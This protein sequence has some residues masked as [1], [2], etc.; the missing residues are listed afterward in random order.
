MT[1]ME[2]ALFWKRLISFTAMFFL[3]TAFPGCTEKPTD[4]PP[5]KVLSANKEEKETTPTVP[6]EKTDAPLAP[7]EKTADGKEKIPDNPASST[8]TE[9]KENPQTKT[10]KDNSISE[11]LVPSNPSPTVKNPSGS[12]DKPKTAAEAKDNENEKSEVKAS[13]QDEKPL[14]DEEIRAESAARRKAALKEIIEKLGPPLVE[15]AEKLIKTDPLFPVWI[16]KESKQVVVEGLVCQTNAPLEMFA[17]L[18][19]TKEHEA[20]LA[21]PTEARVV[22]AAL[23]AVGAKPGK[24]VEFGP[25]PSDYKPATGT[26]IEITVRWKNDKGEIQ[27]GRAQEWIKNVKTGKEMKESWV[28]GGSGFW[29]DEQGIEHYMAEGGDFI[30]VSNF[31]SA[32]LDLPIESRQSN[33]ELTFQ[34]NAER[35]PPRDTPVTVILSPKLK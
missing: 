8:T 34:A 16:D 19:G 18:S 22:H 29:K 26:E 21:I 4:K 6:T 31:S 12:G 1:I 30:C 33:D 13:D 5:Q 28:F 14:T 15:K 24:P 35:I 20:I 2:L 17:V 25:Q 27:T 23:M 3:L 7:T 9:E 10:A 32:M 11:F